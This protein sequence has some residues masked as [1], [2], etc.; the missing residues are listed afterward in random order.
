MTIRT[1]TNRPKLVRSGTFPYGKIEYISTSIGLAF[2]LVMHLWGNITLGGV[3][4]CLPKKK[5]YIHNS[6]CCF[7]RQE[8][9]KK[10]SFGCVLTNAI[11][12]SV[13]YVRRGKH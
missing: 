1:K 2:V 13:F 8:K 6:F 10:H 3:I 9:N 7:L 5:P 12:K 4:K 11:V